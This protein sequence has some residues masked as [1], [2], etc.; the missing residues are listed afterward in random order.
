MKKKK[1]KKIK[2]CGCKGKKGGCESLETPNV[3]LPNKNIKFS[4]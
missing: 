1:Q 2:N 4:L 3:K